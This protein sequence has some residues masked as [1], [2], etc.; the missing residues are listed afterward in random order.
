ML[1]I[2]TNADAFQTS[3]NPENI[4]S[5]HS[6]KKKHKKKK[7]V[8]DE[9]NQDT[10]EADPE[11][12]REKK[13]KRKQRDQEPVVGEVAESEPVLD[14]VPDV[15]LKPKKRKERARARD[16]LLTEQ[17]DAE[18]E[19]NSQASAA[20]L[21]SAIVA[22]SITNPETPQTHPEQVQVHQGQPFVQ[23]PAMQYEYPGPAPPSFDPQLQSVFAPPGGGSAFSEL[24]FGSNEELLRALQDLDMS[25]IAHVLKSLGE[26]AAANTPNPAFAGQLGFIPAQLEQLPPPSLGQLPVGSHAI[27]GIPPKQTV[28][29]PS[30][31]R[32]IDM[33]LP[34]NELH[35]NS[36]HA[37]LLANKWLTASKLADLVRDEGLSLASLWLKNLNLLS[38]VAT[39][40]V[41]KKGKFS[42]IEEQQLRSAVERYKN[43]RLSSNSTHPLMYLFRVVCQEKQLNNEQLHEIIF[44]K[45]D[46][47]KDTAFWSE[48]SA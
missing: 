11:A 15:A 20:A 22:A 13:K 44:A 2:S 1:S 34:G 48:L 37:Y 38:F 42:A 25:K 40:L 19:A 5:S 23:Y 30:H 10:A 36:D 33:S 46:K 16:A 7:R 39:G 9:D 45:A 35:A 47:N 26:A 12:K 29:F 32:T 21:L 27:L 28:A 41:Y 43:V 17:T 4:T 31:K 24:A 18:I 6:E 3:V 8:R 14:V